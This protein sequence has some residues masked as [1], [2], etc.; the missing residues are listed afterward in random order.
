M[1]ATIV[2]RAG[3]RLLG[4]HLA[5]AVLGYVIA[6]PEIGVRCAFTPVVTHFYPQFLDPPN[7]EPIHEGDVIVAVGGRAV[8]N[9]SQ[10]MRKLTDLVD[11]PTEAGV[12]RVQFR[13]PGDPD[14]QVRSVSLRVGQTPLETL[15]PSILWLVL[16]LGLFLIGALVF[17]KRPEDAAAVHF[18]LLCIV[19]LG[20]FIGGYHWARIV[21]QP[22]L[23]LV[24]MTCSL[25]LPSVT[26]HFYPSS[27]G[28]AA[29]WNATR[30]GR[31][32]F[33]TARRP[34][35]WVCCCTPT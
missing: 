33:C 31:W 29:S 1:P 26:L 14:G 25:L 9:W 16:N 30:A 4:F 21:T 20:A 17:W 11:Q 18:F 22:V 10:L 35:F 7:Q 24:F 2:H 13:R 23:L 5:F 19:S 32:R 28:P 8:E 12:V 3:S 27:R 15:V 6:T 34:C